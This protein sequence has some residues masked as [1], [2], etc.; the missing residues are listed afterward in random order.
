MNSG[1]EFGGARV[2]L[3]GQP[4]CSP[5]L[6]IDGVQLLVGCQHRSS[7]L[8]VL[9]DGGA[10]RSGSYGGVAMIEVAENLL[11]GRDKPRS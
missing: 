5:R 3:A 10:D 8:R 7:F 6:G 1:G 11:R 9:V 2:S 4:T